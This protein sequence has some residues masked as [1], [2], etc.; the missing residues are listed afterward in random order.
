MSELVLS[1][2]LR[3]FPIVIISAAAFVRVCAIRRAC[4]CGVRAP[5]L[6]CNVIEVSD[7]SRS[8]PPVEHPLHPHITGIILNRPPDQFKTNKRTQN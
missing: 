8:A 3:N 1:V 2:Q 7:G 5:L 6:C 4:P